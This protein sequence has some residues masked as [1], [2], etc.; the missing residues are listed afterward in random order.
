MAKVDLHLHSSISDGVLSPAGLVEK[1][2]GLGL[3]AI[4][5]TDHDNVDGI[6]P[7][8]KAAARFSTLTFIPGIEISSDI[9]DGEVHILGYFIDHTNPDFL[10][11]LDEM[12]ISRITRARKMIEKLARLGV[13]VEWERVQQVAGDGSVGRPHIAQALLEKG[14]ISTIQEAFTRYLA[15][16]G[17]AYVHRDKLTPEEAIELI[18]NAGGTAVLAHPLTKASSNPEP[19]VQRL[20]KAGLAGLEAHYKEYPQEDREMLIRLADKYGLITTGGSDYHGLDESVEVMIGEAGVPPEVVGNLIEIA[21]KRP[22]QTET[23]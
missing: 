16:N 9:K 23:R 11:R 1:A 12:R 19:L 10:K 21:G 2:A 22:Q 18:I 5:L 4:A 6:A 20:V 15:F 13:R 14:L 8:I 7:A 17:P 3:T